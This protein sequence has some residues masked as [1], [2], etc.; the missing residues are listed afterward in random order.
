METFEQRKTRL[1][2]E[3]SVKKRMLPNLVRNMQS[4]GLDAEAI[5]RI[6]RPVFGI[7]MASVA[8]IRK[9]THIKPV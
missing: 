1:H 5:S 9:I 7:G 6:L 4:E 8:Q 3:A 2:H